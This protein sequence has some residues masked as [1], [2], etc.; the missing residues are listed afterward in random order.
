MET[1]RIR[2]GLV[3]YTLSAAIVLT[4]GSTLVKQ[5]WLISALSCWA[6][7]VPIFLAAAFDRIE[8]D[9]KTIRHCACGR[10]A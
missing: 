4:I 7:L 10:F 3:P 6:L 1:I 2:P 5:G 9:G 8:F